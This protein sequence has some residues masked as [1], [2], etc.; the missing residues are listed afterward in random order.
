[1]NLGDLPADR[2]CNVVES[3][4]EESLLEDKERY[5]HRQKVKAQMKRALTFA[6]AAGITDSRSNPGQATFGGDSYDGPEPTKPFIPPTPMTDN[7]H[8]PFG[9]V[10]DPPMGM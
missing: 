2:A 10:L 3:W 5:E 1:M 6:G 4:F 9:D 7:E 8:K